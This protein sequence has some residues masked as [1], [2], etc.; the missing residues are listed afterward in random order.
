M[1]KGGDCD[2]ADAV[3][4]PERVFDPDA[5]IDHIRA[6]AQKKNTVVIVV[7]EGIR[8]ADGRFVCELSGSADSVDV[9]GHKQLSGC[10]LV[11]ADM[12]SGATGFKTRAIELS[13]LQRSAAHMASLTDVE[14]A[15]LAGSYGVKAA[16][17]GHTGVMTVLKR[18]QDQPYLCAVD[19]H[20]IHMIANR[21]KP[22]P[23][24]WITEDGRGL[25]EE[26]LRY[27]RPLI[28]G[29]LQ[30]LYIDGLPGHLVRKEIIS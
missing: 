21:E 13:T 1:A 14:E 26:F 23:D 18:L 28:M 17:E 24:E 22:V 16:A 6:A 8:L 27:A 7:S 25:T 10:A 2:G 30:P 19:I 29:E 20:D 3:Y 12:V 11:L 9:F 5:C 4:L 15:V